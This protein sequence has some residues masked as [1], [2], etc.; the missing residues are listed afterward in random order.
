MIKAS[1]QIS[2]SISSIQSAKADFRIIAN[3]H[4]CSLTVIICEEY[5]LAK[6]IDE[7]FAKES[8]LNII[9]NMAQACLELNI[10]GSRFQ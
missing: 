5:Q 9:S 10:I 8:W 7:V 1:S 4:Q 2:E 6:V 3:D